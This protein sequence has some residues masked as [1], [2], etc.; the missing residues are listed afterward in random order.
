MPSPRIDAGQDGGHTATSIRKAALFISATA[1]PSVPAVLSENS[2]D[3]ST[4][5]KIRAEY[6]VEKIAPPCP[7]AELFLNREIKR[8]YSGDK[9]YNPPPSRPA[10]LDARVA[11]LKLTFCPFE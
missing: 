10:K 7:V 8:E 9:V 11:E 4:P 6:P 2:I 1:P 5:T 3:P